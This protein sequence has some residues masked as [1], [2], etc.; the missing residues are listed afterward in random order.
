[1]IEADVF[2]MIGD[3]IS[4]AD[5]SSAATV[6]IAGIKK[7]SSVNGPG[8]RYTI[9]FQGCQ[10]DCPG[11]QNADTHDMTGGEERTVDDVISAMLSVSYIDG[12]TLSGGDPLMQPEACAAIAEA[13]RSRDL[14]VWIYTGWTWEEIL[15][16]AAGEG[17]RE[18][19]RHADVVVDGRYV[20]DLNDG[21]TLWRGSSNQRL[22]D[23]QKSLRE[24][25]IILW[26][27]EE[28]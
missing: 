20:E 22:I 15:S 11:C 8:V 4:M 1:M 5:S 18:A 19:V 26:E 14:T 9:F 2:Q 23:A 6:R 13:A 17:A 25:R 16:G 3:V 21:S 27:D 24:G 10:H 7:H 12:V 28:R